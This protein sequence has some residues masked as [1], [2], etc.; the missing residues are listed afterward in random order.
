MFANRA[1]YQ[2]DQR[3][4]ILVDNALFVSGIST[5]LEHH[6]MEVKN[7]NIDI[8]GND[9]LNNLIDI[10]H[11]KSDE[12]GWKAQTIML[13]NHSSNIIIIKNDFDYEEIAR[14]IHIGVKGICLTEIDEQFLI[15]I[16]NQ[17]Q[18][19]KFFLDY[20][21]THKVV[22][23]NLRLIDLIN[24]G[25]E[26]DISSMQILLT[27]REIEILQL[28]GKGYSN[29]QIG[30]ELYISDK[31]VKNHVSNIINKME[32]PDRLNAV[33]LA[34]KNKWISLY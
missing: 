13:Q 14:L 33:I 28:L 7:L 15:Q 17:V 25:G 6:N 19:G 20:R 1:L 5:I 3:T 9:S 32:V 26:L 2:H 4:I 34:L 23:E 10:F 27:R 11:V 16:V 29:I 24:T 21:L 12:M 22:E 18:G 31:T 30:N 8:L